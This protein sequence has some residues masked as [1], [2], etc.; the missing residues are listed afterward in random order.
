M[1]RDRPAAVGGPPAH[2]PLVPAGAPAPAPMP[3][4]AAARADAAPEPQGAD[5]APPILGSWRRMYILV[6]A[7]FAATVLLFAWLTRVYE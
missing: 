5:D 6:L 2:A 3:S 7:V 4:V 1:S